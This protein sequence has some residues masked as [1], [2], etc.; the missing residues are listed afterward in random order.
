VRILLG[1]GVEA[2]VV[3]EVE[4]GFGLGAMVVD[5]L[6]D[7]S[8]MTCDALSGFRTRAPATMRA[9]ETAGYATTARTRTGRDLSLFMR[10]T[11]GSRGLLIVGKRHRVVR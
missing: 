1:L 5:G 4:V 2:G 6:G 11:G 3:L 10:F 7:A 8:A 9:T